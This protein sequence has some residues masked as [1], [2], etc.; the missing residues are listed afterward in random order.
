M[1]ILFKPLKHFLLNL[2]SSTPTGFI[3]L[4]ILG[5][6]KQTNKNS[7]YTKKFNTRTIGFALFQIYPLI[8]WLK[9]LHHVSHYFTQ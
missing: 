9:N 5:L 1:S 3:F 8:L 4:L 2:L 7:H 6:L